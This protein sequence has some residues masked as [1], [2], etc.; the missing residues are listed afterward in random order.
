M[1]SMKDTIDKIA[2]ETS[3]TS[4]WEGEG[5]KKKERNVISHTVSAYWQISTYITL[6]F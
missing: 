5:K 2:A 6:V 3:N 4:K 1:K